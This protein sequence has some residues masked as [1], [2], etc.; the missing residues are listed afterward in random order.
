MVRRAPARGRRTRGRNRCAARPDERSGCR[1]PAVGPRRGRAD[2]GRSSPAARPARRGRSRLPRPRPGRR[3]P[4]PVSS[5]TPSGTRAS[6]RRAP[7]S[8][9]SGTRARPRRAR[10]AS[11]R[12]LATRP[13]R[14]DTR[15]VER[16]RI[17]ARSPQATVMGYSRAVRVG[18]HVFVG[19]TAPVMPE[20]QE[21]PADAYGQAARCLE[22][23]VGALR[24][25]G[26]GPEH[27]VRTRIFATDANDFTEIARAHD[28]VFRR[29]VSGSHVRA[30][31]A[32]RPTLAGRDRS[33]GADLVKQAY[34]PSITGKGAGFAEGG[35]VLDHSFGKGDPYTLGVEEE[36]MLLDG[37]TF[38]LVQ[39]VDTVLAAVAGH[40]LEER[41][42]P[43][44]MQSVIEITTPVCRTPADVEREL[45][46]AARVRHERGGGEGPPRRLCR[47]ASVQPVRAAADHGARPLPQPRRPDAVRRA[48]RAD[49]RDA[50][51]RGGRRAGEGDPGGERPARPPPATP[52]PDRELAVLARRADRARLAAGRWSSPPFHA[53]GRRRASATTPTT[54][55]SSASSSA[56]AASPTTRI[57]G[58]TSGCTPASGTVEVRICDAV[59]R[60][61]GRGR[62]RG[63]LPG[64]RQ[65]LLRA[66]RPGRGDPVV[67]PD[68]HRREQVARR[69][70]RAGGARDRPRHRTAEPR[71]GRPAHPADAPRPRAARTRARLRARARGH[72][73]R[74]SAAATAPTG[75]CGS[76]TRTA[77]SSRSRREIADTTEA[78]PVEA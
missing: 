37:E 73:R 22:I 12:R 45:S 23:I 32:P 13:L 18:Q 9:R 74:S 10:P 39:H 57:S 1:P 33:R 26:A 76:T 38:D 52:R 21:P 49:L 59:T 77:T 42:N 20:G 46:A 56:R 15:V 71:P 55:R 35:S 54:P 72:P 7:Q 65:A 16:Q 61:R 19:G 25:A 58:G 3:A 27:V 29:R 69:P 17:E 60:A 47:D 2:A 75:S 4:S 8:T 66:V 51:P 40:E 78:V 70:L 50:R 43:E 6:R 36:Y 62:H 64:A 28:E 63:V 34:P 31:E 14:L 53:P 67:P 44:L 5:P 48:A 24:E 68:P 11:P 41:I 30:R